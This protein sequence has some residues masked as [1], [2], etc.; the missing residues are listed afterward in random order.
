MEKI[1][2]PNIL[3]MSLRR[4]TTYIPNRHIFKATTTTNVYSIDVKDRVAATGGPNPEPHP[5]YVRF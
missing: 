3:G 1:T 4:G 2:R 5:Q